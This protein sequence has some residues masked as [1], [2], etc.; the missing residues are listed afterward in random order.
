MLIV[1][2]WKY[3]HLYSNFVMVIMFFFLI[4]VCY[5]E[6]NIWLCQYYYYQYINLYGL[7]FFL[8]KFHIIKKSP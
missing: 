8:I 1:H 4:S 2:S 7:H 6:F 3:I 5:Q